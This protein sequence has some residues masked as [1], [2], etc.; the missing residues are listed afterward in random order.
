M[1]ELEYNAGNFQ[2]YDYETEWL[3]CDWKAVHKTI[4]L[5]TAFGTLGYINNTTVQPL[6]RK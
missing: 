1:Q 5:V 2:E 6:G 3:E 4:H